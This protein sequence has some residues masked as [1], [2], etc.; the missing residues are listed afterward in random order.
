LVKERT[1]KT[2]KFLPSIKS[3]EKTYTLPKNWAWCRLAD[4]IHITSGDALPSHKMA[5]NGNIPV[6]GGNGITGYHDQ[7]NVHKSTLVIGRVGFYCGSVHIAPKLAWVT[8]NAFITYFSESNIDFNFLYWLLKGSNLGDRNN[9]TAQPVI[10]GKKVYPIVVALPPFEEQKRIVAKVDQLMALCDQLESFQ[11][12]KNERRIQLNNSALSKMLDA[13]SPD[14]FVKHWQ[15]VCENF[16]LLY[17]NLENVEKLKQAILQLAVQGKLVE[18]DENGESTEVLL[19][20]IRAEKERLVKEGKIKK[21][22]PLPPIEGDEIPYIIPEN[23]EW[24]RLENIGIINPRNNEDD[25]I[26][27]S[28]VPMTLISETYGKKPESETTLWKEIK[29]GYTHFAEKDVVLA[30]ITPCFQNKKSAVMT[31]LKNGFGAGTTELHVFRPINDTINPEYVLVYLKSPKFIN[32]GIGKMTGSAGQKRVPKDYFSQNPFPLPPIEEQKR[33]V[34][35]VNQ[36]ME[37]C[38][39]L[40]TGIKQA[41]SDSDILMEVAVKHL[42]KI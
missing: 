13:G 41:Q 40:E 19:G 22:K 37:H 24:T 6:Y 5:V 31:N 23:W 34:T 30:K 36:L 9:S 20:E 27:A 26:E 21:S 8:D 15:L 1:I 25:G 33:I 10:S 42:L 35:K 29:K 2:S 32:E 14:E 16:D 28:F 11:Q 38:N 18:Q 17:D 7:Y 3:E 39:Q 12:K 4:I